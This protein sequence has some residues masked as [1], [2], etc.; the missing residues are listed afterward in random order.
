MDHSIRRLLAASA[1]GQL[2]DLVGELALAVAVFWATGSSVALAA[3]WIAQRALLAWAAPAL[4]VRLPPGALAPLYLAQ[5]AVALA[6]FA[7]L[8]SAVGPALVV[9]AIDGLLAPSARALSRTALVACA[10]TA[11]RIGVVNARASVAVAAVG[12]LAPLLGGALLV[13]AEPR[14]AFAFDAA[15]ALVAA[16]LVRGVAIPA[17]ADAPVRAAWRFV[18]AHRTARRLLAG[19]AALAVCM[20][21]I[22]PVEVALVCGTLGASELGLGAVLTAWGAGM[23]AGGVLVTRLAWSERL[24]L[25]LAA[26][27]PAV[28]CMGIAASGTLVPVVGWSV[29]GGLGNG[30]YGAVFLTALHRRTPMSCQAGVNAFYDV[31]G[32]VAPGIGFALGGLIAA[33]GSARGAYAF[34]GVGSLLVAGWLSGIIER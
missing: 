15:C 27:A 5:A 9:L 3:V 13:V 20:A 32:S 12:L 11:E 28:A 6:L 29:L 19:D 2:G 30:V 17:R 22:A 34:A 10:G 8:F 16:L 18:R 33:A 7:G 4:V 24:L 14:A 23:L 25:V 21:A 26:A 1:T 31:I